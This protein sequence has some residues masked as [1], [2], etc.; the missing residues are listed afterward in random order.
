MWVGK[1][2]VGRVV[3]EVNRGREESVDQTGDFLAE[4]GG[5]GETVG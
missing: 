2:G 5:F 3:S 1:G 4:D